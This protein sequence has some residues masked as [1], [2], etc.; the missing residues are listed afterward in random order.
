MTDETYIFFRL[1]S[2]EAYAQTQT[3]LDAS[4]GFPDAYTQ[5]ALPDWEHLEEGLNG[6]KYLFIDKWRLKPEDEE[7]ISDMVGAGYADLIL[8]EEYETCIADIRD[9]IDL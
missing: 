7:L 3:L 2:A 1:H 6:K 8:M 4:R 9:D 5:Q